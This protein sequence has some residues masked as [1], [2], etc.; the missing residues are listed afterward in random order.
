MDHEKRSRKRESFQRWR[1]RT[2]SDAFNIDG[3]RILRDLGVPRPRSNAIM[4]DPAYTALKKDCLDLIRTEGRRAFEQSSA[5][6]GD[7]GLS[8]VGT[9]LELTGSV[10]GGDDESSPCEHRGRHHAGGIG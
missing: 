8:V 3:H 6:Q 7:L 2:S 1:P 9:S 4:L 5:G 10:Q